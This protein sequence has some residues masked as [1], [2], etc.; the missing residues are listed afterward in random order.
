MRK[1]L[2][3]WAILCIFSLCLSGCT[4]IPSKQK[5]VQTTESTETT[6]PKPAPNLESVKYTIERNDRSLRDENNYV[7]IEHFYELVTIQG[8]TASIAA[9]NESL[10]KDMD[11]FFFTEAELDEYSS[12]PFLSPEYPLYNTCEAEVTHNY[13]GYFGVKFSTSWM[14]GGVGNDDTYG[15]TYNLNTGLPATLAELTGRNPSSL[16]K[17]LKEIVWAFL[18]NDFGETPMYNARETLDNYK[19]EEFDFYLLDGEIVLLFPTDTFGS[20]AAGQVI[21]ETGIYI[22]GC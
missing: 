15:L 1:Y 10:K 14:M 19:L 8:S 12:S 11:S 2:S 16:E 22:I 9:I 17:Q 13:N 20:V 3:F 4:C 5:P 6:V 21:V 18:I 7:L